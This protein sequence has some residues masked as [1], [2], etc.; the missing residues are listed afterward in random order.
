MNDRCRTFTARCTLDHG[1]SGPHKADAFT[2]AGLTTERDILRASLNEAVGL[3]RDAADVINLPWHDKRRAFLSRL[4][5]G[6][7]GAR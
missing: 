6:K 7:A 2:F 4:D 1:H 3:L 5:A